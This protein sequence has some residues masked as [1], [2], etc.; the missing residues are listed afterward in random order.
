MTIGRR[1]PKRSPALGGMTWLSVVPVDRLIDTLKP[2]E[3]LKVTGNTSV[4]LSGLHLSADELLLL[5]SDRFGQERCP[6][7]LHGARQ[8]GGQTR[9]DDHTDDDI[10][11]FNIE[12]SIV[13]Q[14]LWLGFANAFG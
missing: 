11:L 13:I 5:A 2:G 10:F 6:L 14:F 8:T 1:R 4:Y 7:P 12:T 9:V 3:V